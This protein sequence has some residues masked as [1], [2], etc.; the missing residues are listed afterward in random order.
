MKFSV[1]L[2]LCTIVILALALGFSGFY[3]VNHVFESS[4]HREVGQ[5]M[6]ESS[7]LGF[8][9]ETAALNIPAKYSVLPDGTVE[10]IAANLERSGQ[11]ASRLIRISGEEK[12][13][14]Y[15][16][17]GF[18]ADEALLAAADTQTKSYRILRTENG[19]YIHTSLAVTTPDR[20]LYLE[21][22]KD[23]SEVF[24]ERETGFSLYRK[25]TVVMLLTGTLLM[26][27][28]ASLLT[29][30]IRILTGATRRM[31]EGDYRYRAKQVSRD[32]L[33][34]LTA[35]FNH[36]V[37]VLEETIEKLEA[38]ISAKEDFVAAFAHELKTPLTA[39]IGYADM[40]R[41]HK[42]DE[43]KS[44]LSANYIY[45]E[46]KRLEAMSFRLLDIIVTK[47]QEITLQNISASSIAEY[48][49]D[50]FHADR[51]WEFTFQCEE[52]CVCAEGNL[53]K[54]VLVNL[55]DNACKASEPGSLISVTGEVTEQ[56][57]RFAVR[58]AGIGI[59][60]EELHKITQPFYMVD[61]SRARSKNGAGLGLALCVEILRLHHSELHIESTPGEGA[62]ISF[63]LPADKKSAGSHDLHEGEKNT[64]SHSLT[65]DEKNTGSHSLTRDEKN[66][67]IHSLAPQKGG[68]SAD[69][70]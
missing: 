22:M 55:I 10:E 52:G 13:V 20:I 49:T 51:T 32:E 39:I 66:A 64:G 47:K 46:G 48:L 8:A 54:T 31:A 42:L 11:N 57:Y 63:T 45:T 9:F 65:R 14:L 35:D 21:L 6:D 59:P 50:M 53:I 15:A 5:A 44:L 36:M 24:K 34:Q 2:L 33:R 18:D 38:E 67:G 60:E 68:E 26:H 30:P 56:G 29:R 19:Y 37:A 4:L 17:P 62:C 1:K 25:V 28:I 12:N 23:V 16:S 58:D 70:T 69:E 3:F 27:L 7:I 41:S 61:K 40:L 43:E